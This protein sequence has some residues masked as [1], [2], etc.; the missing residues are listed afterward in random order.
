M[1]AGV[2]LK[3]KGVI[4]AF[5]TESA[6]VTLDIRVA[7]HMAVKKSLEAKRLGTYATREFAAAAALFLHNNW[8]IKYLVTFP[9]AKGVFF[10]LITISKLIDFI[11]HQT[12]IHQ[13]RDNKNN[14]TFEL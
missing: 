1:C 13:I 9:V 14:K 8:K 12:Q 6:E 7:L 2:A 11:K 4:E 5:A 10:V 3:V